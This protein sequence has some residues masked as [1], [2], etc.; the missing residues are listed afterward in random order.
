MTMN[1]FSIENFPF[2]N[3]NLLQSRIAWSTSIRW[4]IVAGY[5]LGTFVGKY[6]LEISMPYMEIWIVL[7]VL[8]LINF[9]YFLLFRFVREFSFRAE[10]LFLE[11]QILIDLVIL[12]LLIHLSGGVENPIYLFYAFHIVLSSII[13]PGWRPIMVTTLATLFFASLIYLEYT[14]QVL[15]YCMF[16][17]D[18][19][20]NLHFI[21]VVFTVFVITMYTTMYIC[22][23]FMRIYRGIKRK[24]DHQNEQLLRAEKQRTQFFRFTSHELKSPVVAIKSTVDGVLAS[25]AKSMDPRAVDLLQRASSRAAQ[26]LDIIRELLDLSK[27]R[28]HAPAAGEERVDIR[29]LLLEIIDQYRAQAGEKL[30]DIVTEIDDNL[31]ALPGNKEDFSKIFQNLISN[32]IRYT[33][34]NGTVRIKTEAG[35]QVV[36]VI[37]A[38]TGI[39][40][41]KQDLKKVYD[42]FYRSENAKKEITFGTGLGL[43]IVKQ[44][45]SN[46]G[47]TIKVDSAVDKGTVFTVKLPTH[48]KMP[49]VLKEL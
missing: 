33:K 36:Q 43:S 17:A 19:H 45:V 25:F 6:Y 14:G 2:L 16:G 4:F 27:N 46:Y 38:D 34:Q 11:I 32:A 21:I 26:M 5:F 8:A 49:H 28:S 41:P 22:M 35:R 31:H 47:G 12:T 39:G 37:V 44:I 3:L 9:M 42:E 1:T 48:L 18:T 20:R 10:V 29:V 23:T 24:L 7:M 30:V 13:F 40:I 15:H